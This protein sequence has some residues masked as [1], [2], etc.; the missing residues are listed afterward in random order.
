M[1]PNVIPALAF[2]AEIRDERP[3]FH[4]FSETALYIISGQIKRIPTFC[5]VQVRSELFSDTL[6][7]GSRKNKSIIKYLHYYSF[8][9][10]ADQINFPVG[11]VKGVYITVACGTYIV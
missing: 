4:V 11:I 9:Y 7:K 5:C 8:A 3:L 10:I 6:L 2:Y 1:V